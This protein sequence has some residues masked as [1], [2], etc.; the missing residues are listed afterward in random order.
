M[1]LLET[2]KT[3]AIDAIN[4][5]KPGE[6]VLGIVF[7]SATKNRIRAKIIALRGV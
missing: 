1:N 3:A 7:H 6:I 5:T 4:N 2:I